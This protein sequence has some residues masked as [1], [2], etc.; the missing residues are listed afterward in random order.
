[1]AVLI[2]FPSLTNYAAE[3]A[4]GAAP[5]VAAVSIA[6]TVASTVDIAEASTAASETAELAADDQYGNICDDLHR[7]E[8]I[9]TAEG[10]EYSDAACD[11]PAR[12]HSV[13]GVDVEAV[14]IF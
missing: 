9:A 13:S 6:D 14:T 3:A 2:E 8:I 7:V 5:N 1:M 4:V 11:M 12:T 10:D